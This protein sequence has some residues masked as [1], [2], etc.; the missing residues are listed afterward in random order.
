MSI[1][2]RLLIF[3][4]KKGKSSQNCVEVQ[5][6]PDSNMPNENIVT[7]YLTYLKNHSVEDQIQELDLVAKEIQVILNK[8]TNHNEN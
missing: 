8:C 5:E 6:C 4:L 7:E 2:E 3:I 1:F